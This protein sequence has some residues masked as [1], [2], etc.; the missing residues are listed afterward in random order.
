M[1]VRVPSFG[2]RAGFVFSKH[3]GR[4]GRVESLEPRRLY[5]STSLTVDV[6]LNGSVQF[7]GPG[8]TIDTLVFQHCAGNVA[9]S[10]SN[11]SQTTQKNGTSL[12]TGTIS[13]IQQLNVTSSSSNASLLFRGTGSK[14]PV[15]LDGLTISSPVRSLMLSGLFLNSATV[16]TQG[17]V[18]A[19][20][21][22][23]TNT[24]LQFSEPSSG[25]SSGLLS[26]TTGNVTDS[27]ISSDLP[28][29]Q[30]QIGAFTA[31][32]PYSTSSGE[33]G[34][35]VITAPS[36]GNLRIAGNLSGDLDLTGTSGSDLRSMVASGDAT[37]GFWNINGGAGTITVRSI[38]SSVGCQ[39]TGALQSLRTSGDEA[40]S[41][42]VGSANSINIGGSLTGNGFEFTNPFSARSYDLGQLHVNGS[43]TDGFLLSTGNV[44]SISA[45]GISGSFLAAG[46]DSGFTFSGQPAASDLTTQAVIRSVT[47]RSSSAQF[48]GSVIAGYELGQLN[49]GVVAVD[50]SGVPFGLTAHQ[51]DSARFAA[52]VA[53]GIKSIT[54]KNAT[55]ATLP[56][57]LQKAGVT[58][59]DL[60]DFTI[61]L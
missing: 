46:L 47:L 31:T 8:T 53:G 51:I 1:G 5:S 36:I 45:A 25:G 40:G 18:L 10:G 34:S 60:K 54:L 56:A 6:P 57:E 49:L 20:F 15:E 41:I 29:S 3:T 11:L 43:I 50:D 52:S 61:R 28:M 39:I 24:S 9:F 55:S 22:S 21:G 17:T 27:L 37:A 7:A 33:G 48:Q 4:A 44:N 32:T 14:T 12:V 30:L 13:L 2:R 26:L 38:A 23:V 35:A 42:V 59:A 58:T 16:T 19:Q